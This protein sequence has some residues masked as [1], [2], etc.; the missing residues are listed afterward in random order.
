VGDTRPPKDDNNYYSNCSRRSVWLGPDGVRVADSTSMAAGRARGA[1]EREVLAC[2][3][4]AGE[5]I[6]AGDVHRQLG[7]DLAY[8]TVMTTLSR[9]YDKGALRRSI[10]G[11]AYT[12]ELIGGPDGARSNVTAHQMLRLLDAGEDRAGVLARF[13]ADLSPQDEE[14]LSRLLQGGE[15]DPDRG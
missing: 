10:V 5:P 12:Y 8:T 4:A 11:R 9:L 2:L 1:L 14:L 7:G 13:V 6:T 3:A 15:L